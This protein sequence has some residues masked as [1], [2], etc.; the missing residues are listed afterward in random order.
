MIKYFKFMVYAMVFMGC[1]QVIELKTDNDFKGS[2]F[3]EGLLVVGQQPH[4]YFSEALPFAQSK[5][6]PQQVFA[7]GAEV[8]L[9]TGGFSELLLADSVFNSFRCRWEPFYSGENKILFGATYDLLI[10]YKGN[11]FIAT[12]TINQIK[13]SIEKIGYNPEFFD[14]YGGH[15]GVNIIL[16][17]PEGPGNFYRF[18]M[19]RRIDNSVAHAHILDVIQS[20]CTKEG[21]KFWVTDLGRTVFSDAGNDGRDLDL[22]VEVSFEYSEGD[23]T[24]ITMQSLDEKAAI[25]YKEL[26]DQLISIIN[27]FVEPVFLESKIDGGAV[28]FF[29]SA[30]LSDSVLFVY[31]QDNP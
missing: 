5:V 7:R 19:N 16:R 23:S 27:P 15:D 9:S 13:P 10:K 18:Q 11:S 21:E 12:T 24:W 8:M 25:F 2:V 3:V 6:T 4:I 29:G 31:P 20:T 28:G 1:E 22:L 26:D 14:I 30:V 17:D